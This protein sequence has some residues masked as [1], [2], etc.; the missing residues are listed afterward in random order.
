L[1][2]EV[3]LYQTLTFIHTLVYSYVHAH[4]HTHT[5]KQT[6]THTHTHTHIHTN[7]KRGE[8]GKERER[9]RQR[10]GKTEIETKPGEGWREIRGEG[11]MTQLCSR[12]LNIFMGPA[13]FIIKD[14]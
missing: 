12:L 1:T 13:E 2:E 4:M 3:I 6:H 10:D 7:R 11:R 8:G 5:H 14:E 9:E